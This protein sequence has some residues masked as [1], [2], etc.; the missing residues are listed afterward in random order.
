[1]FVAVPKYNFR[2]WCAATFGPNSQEVEG[3]GTAPW[4]TAGSV[5]PGTAR[6][7]RVRRMA[8]EYIVVLSIRGS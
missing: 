5:D 2:A 6:L 4:A 8:A 3:L 7:A 1:M